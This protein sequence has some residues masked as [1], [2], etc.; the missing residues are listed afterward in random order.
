MRH[1]PIPFI[2]LIR[3]TCHEGAG[4][5]R[6]IRDRHAKWKTDVLLLLVADAS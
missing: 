3:S 5:V 6:V 2:P 4:I 1:A